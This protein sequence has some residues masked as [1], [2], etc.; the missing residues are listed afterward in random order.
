[1]KKCCS[2]AITCNCLFV[3]MK[4][5]RN[6]Q[7]FD[8]LN[9]FS[10]VFNAINALSVRSHQIGF[11]FC[12]FLFFC[13]IL[14]SALVSI[15]YFYDW[16]NSNGIECIS[17]KKNVTCM[18]ERAGKKSLPIF[19]YTYTSIIYSLWPIFL[20]LHWNVYRNKECSV[21]I[22]RLE[23][24]AYEK[25]TTDNGN[26][27]DV[28]TLNQIAPNGGQNTPS[29]PAKRYRTRSSLRLGDS[30]NDHGQIER[31]KSESASVPRP[32]PAFIEYKGKVE[33]FTEFHDIAFA[34]DNLL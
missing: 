22:E 12:S 21:R 34:S 30:N 31:K 11:N 32:K 25:K 8:T 3:C 10:I 19:L 1:M 5:A 33:Y 14:L 4:M 7:Y 15:E 13:W 18:D 24:T 20:L 26:E 17:C 16:L 2:S 23:S 28:N 27:N 9:T 6:Q 29:S